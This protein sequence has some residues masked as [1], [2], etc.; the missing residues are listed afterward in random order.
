MKAGVRGAIGVAL[1]GLLLWWALKD[2]PVASVSAHL[3]Q[4]NL[5]L[6]V[7]SAFLATAA[8][9]LRAM[10]WRPILA[11]LHA[12]LPFGTLW[13]PTAIGL[14]IN[15]VVPARAGEVAR[16]YALTREVPQIPFTA[17]FASVAVDRVIDAIVLLTLMF[18]AMLDPRF[19]SDSTI[20]GTPVHRLAMGGL[21]VA[22]FGAAVLVA[23][24]FL[25]NVVLR[26]FE[27]LVGSISKPLERK[28]RGWLVAFISGLAVLRHPTRFLVVLGWAVLFWLVNALAFWVGFVAVGIDVPYSAALFL[29]AVIAIGIAVPQ[30]PGFFGMFEAVGKA[31]LAVYG[32]PDEKAVAWAIGF[33]FVSFLPITIIG[34][35]YFARMGLHLGDVRAAASADNGS[36]PPPA[37][38]LNVEQ[39]E[40]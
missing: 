33:H 8:F 12:P 14:M 34:A 32:V 39:Q 10:R 30:M 17:A 2:V 24:V 7:L 37:P 20:G 4:S 13:R 6:L 26:V 23:L 38:Q 29:Q 22:L 9:P 21:A 15:N 3:Q 25:P 28:T 19:A 11:P 31:G 5:W 35:I 18:L 27:I 36:A 16:A 40:G 1:S